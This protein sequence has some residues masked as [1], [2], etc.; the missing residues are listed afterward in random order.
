MLRSVSNWVHHPHNVFSQQHSLQASIVIRK[1]SVEAAVSASPSPRSVAL[2]ILLSSQRT[3]CPLDELIDQRATLIPLPRDRSL[4]M[5]LAYGVLRRQETID[6]RLSAILSK[7]LRRLP[8]FVQMVL[9]VGAYQLLFLDRIPASAAVD[10]TVKLAKASA[11]Q[12]GRDWSGLVNGVLRS[13]IR[14]PAPTLPDS[15]S[16]PVEFLSVRYG[17]PVWLTTRWVH[18]MGSERA[19]SACLATSVVPAVTLRV[20]RCRLTR[21]E[22]LERVR[23]AGIAIRAADVSPVGAVLEKGQD[24]TSLPGFL[25]GD[26]YVED[27]AAQLIPPILDPQPGEVIL[28]A[29]AAP[30]G[31]ASHLAALMGDR[32]TI[33]AVDRKTSR[34][35]LLQQNCRRLGIQSVVPIVGDVRRTSEWSAMIGQSNRL[36]K[37]PLFDRVLVDAPCSGLGVLRRH[38]E[39]KLRKESS[40]LAS[41]QKLQA[42]VLESV[43][44]CLRPGGV[45]VYSTCSTEMEETEEVVSRFC[46][47]YPG[48]TRESVAPW[49]PTSALLFVTPQGALSTLCNGFGMDGFYAVRLRKNG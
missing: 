49:V 24:I 19:E 48:W 9:R 44:P 21:E 38:P 22:F 16:H 4:V 18:R 31:K 11:Q 36:G 34:L 2:A 37:L 29:C 46:E 13:L 35:D 7:P 28:D 30:G 17:I 32:G 20:N 6:W 42:Q 23:Q 1:Q 14:L 45:L 3:D 12:L 40:V 39:A 27:E 43:A 47:A 33:Y 15:I 8:A 5:E 26:F 10:E 25:A 41:H